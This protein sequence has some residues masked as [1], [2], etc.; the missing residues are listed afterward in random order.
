MNTNPNWRQAAAK[1][2]RDMKSH[3]EKLLAGGLGML[4]CLLASNV[5]AQTNANPALVAALPETPNVLYG[6][7]GQVLNNPASVM[8]IPFLM[9]LA[10]LVDDLPFINSRYVVHITVITGASIY[11]AFT[12]VDTVPKSF[13]HPLMVFVVNG[14]ICGFVA[15]VGHRQAIARLINMVQAHTG[16][17]N[18]A[19]DGP[20]KR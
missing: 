14:T 2:E 4:F 6:M 7:Y 11:W 18:A 8:V 19:A 10:W 20:G 5:M 16:G 12:S 17:G 15:F 13:P 3:Q 9:V 1:L